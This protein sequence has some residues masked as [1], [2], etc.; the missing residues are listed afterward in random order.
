MHARACP[1]DLYMKKVGETMKLGMWVSVWENLSNEQIWL[2][3]DYG[4]QEGAEVIASCSD[5]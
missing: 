5:D 2:T 1:F 4:Y 3:L